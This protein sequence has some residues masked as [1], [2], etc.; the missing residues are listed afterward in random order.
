MVSQNQS[1]A[2]VVSPS[3]PW[4]MNSLAS[5]WNMWSYS[6]DDQLFVLGGEAMSMI[7]WRN[8]TGQDYDSIEVHGPGAG[9]AR[10]RIQTAPCDPML[11]NNVVPE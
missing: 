11:R 7:A 2:W 1:Q 4:F 10:R 3:W 8:E 9:S 5:D 6:T